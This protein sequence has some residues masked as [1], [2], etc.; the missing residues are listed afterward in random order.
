MTYHLS[1]VCHMSNFAISTREV[2]CTRRQLLAYKGD[3][4]KNTTE[5]GC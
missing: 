2:I 3:N 5:S 1:L 4:A